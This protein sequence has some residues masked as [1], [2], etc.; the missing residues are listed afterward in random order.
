MNYLSKVE[1]HLHAEAT[2]TARDFRTRFVRKIPPGGAPP[3]TP[4]RV[5]DDWGNPHRFSAYKSRMTHLV[6]EIHHT[7]LTT[8]K[9]LTAF[10]ILRRAGEQ[11]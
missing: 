7:K 3:T 8:D 2:R 5:E 10:E 1:E 6:N 11:R 4:V 9:Q